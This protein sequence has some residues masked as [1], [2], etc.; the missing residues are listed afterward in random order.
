MICPKCG[1]I[2]NNS[3]AL[4]C[5]ACGSKI[6]TD[7]AD[8]QLHDIIF[9]IAEDSGSVDIALNYLD[10][11]ENSINNLENFPYMGAKPRYA[12]LRRQ[13]YRVLV[14]ERHLAFYKIDEEAKTAIIYAVMDG[15]RE[16]KDLI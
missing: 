1:Y 4:Y 10:K 6:T 11:I 9:Y 7:K 15:R 12:T 8:E 16:Y 2:I 3:N 5:P 14:V 13:G